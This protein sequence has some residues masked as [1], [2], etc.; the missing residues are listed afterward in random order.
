M[1]K[2]PIGIQ[3]FREI[4]DR[5]TYYVDKTPLIDYILSEYGTEVFLFTRP[6]RF[7]KSVNLSMLDS[8]LNRRFV[9]NTWFDE[10][11]ITDLRP[12][13]PEKNSYP[14]LYLDMKELS[15]RSVEAFIGDLRLIISDQCKAHLE[16]LD[17][18]RLDPDSRNIFGMLMSRTSDETLLMR[19]LR[20]LSRLLETHYGRKAVILIDEYDS[21]LNGA[22]GTGIQNQV[23]VLVR[24]LLTSA[25]KGNSSL[26]LG[27]VTGVMQIAKESIFGGLN[28]MRVN[29]ILSKDV[30]EMFGFTPEE[31]GRLCSDF[32]HPERFDE[33]QEWYDGYRFGE[34]DIYNPWS[35][36]NYVGSGFIPDTYWAGTSGNSIV[37]DLL[38]IPDSRIYEELNVLGSGG[39]ISSVLDARVTFADMNERSDGIYSVMAMSGYLRVSCDGM[40]CT[41][42][43]PNR[44]IY[45]VFA[46]TIISKLDA[47]GLDRGIRRFSD[48]VLSNDT[49][50]M[51]QA[52]ED[53]LMSA[54]SSRV[55]ADEHSYQAFIT[56]LLMSMIGRYR[57]TADHE[58]G[59]GYHD[60]LMERI[61]GAGPNVVIEVKRARGDQD[62]RTLAEEALGQIH[63]RRY[64]HGLTG[65]T[66]L[67]GV[68]FDGKRPTIVSDEVLL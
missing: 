17:S 58:S 25:L 27:V 20:L 19:S 65:R 8:Y 7:G 66:I 16:L 11:K 42:S 21:P 62:P 12:E 38:S 6:R 2:V 56:G 44:E 31:V 60:I 29:N 32:G 57:I 39:S 52:L 35:V 23:L 50:V 43:I 61:R 41:M 10:L 3:S 24:E 40:D 67:Y 64:H 59:F 14:V 4:R 15:V 49:D 1:M 48:A 51:T 33:A 28:N 9:G 53:M 45:S 5:G 34:A 26:R 47:R 55:L 13:D 46:D 68:A 30:D 54:M 18:E 63:D 37:D 22:Y 36:L